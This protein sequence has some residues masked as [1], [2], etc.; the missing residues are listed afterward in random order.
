[1]E[2]VRSYDEFNTPVYTGNDR[3]RGDVYNDR[4]AAARRWIDHPGLPTRLDGG[5][6][7]E[8]RPLLLLDYHKQNQR[9][10]A[11]DPFGSV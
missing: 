5:H 3:C 11:V 1:M 7:P 4:P 9:M 6:L 10:T 8:L 2:M